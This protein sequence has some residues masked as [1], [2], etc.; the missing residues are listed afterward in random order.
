MTQWA[1]EL[2]LEHSRYPLRLDLKN[3]TVVADTIDGAVPMDRM[4]SA[5]NWVG[6]HLIAHLDLHEWFV[7]RS[8]PVPRM[9]FIDQL[10]QVYFP[11][12]RDA[13]GSLSEISEEDQQAVTRMLKFLL[14]VVEELAPHFQ[15][16]ITEHADIA[17]PWYRNT[18]IERWRGAGHMLVPP[19][20]PRQ[21]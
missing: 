1:N 20:W 19:D 15:V 7:N 11:A 10:S 16:I 4:G 13:D 18:V 5:E 2:K 6:Y 9:L 17:E 21:E 12:D 14:S 8:L 3:L